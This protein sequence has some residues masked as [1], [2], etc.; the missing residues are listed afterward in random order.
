MFDNRTVFI[1]LKEAGQE[2]KERGKK[3]QLQPTLKIL[4]IEDSNAMWLLL[5]LVDVLCFCLEL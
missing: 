2:G 3:N 4:Q 5:K 1:S